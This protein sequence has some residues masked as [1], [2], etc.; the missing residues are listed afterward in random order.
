MNN[1]ICHRA[2]YRMHLRPVARLFINLHFQYIN[3]NI[4]DVLYLALYCLTLLRKI[5]QH[6]DIQENI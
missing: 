6:F 3:K 4:V 2:K 5:L 1:S